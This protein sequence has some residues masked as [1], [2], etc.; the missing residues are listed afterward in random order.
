MPPRRKTARR[1]GPERGSVQHGRQH[2][3]PS[4]SLLCRPFPQELVDLIID[5]LY[6]DFPTLQI[7]SL[8]S[9]SFL[10]S[11][12]RHQFSHIEFSGIQ[13]PNPPTRQWRRLTLNTCEK[14][15]ALISE[16]PHIAPLVR[17][18]RVVEGSNFLKV[19]WLATEP[20]LPVVLRK[21]VNLTSISLE[22][23]DD[24]LLW[25]ALSH[26]LRESLSELFRS[27]KL[28]T[29]RFNEIDLPHPSE[30]FRMFEGSNLKHLLLS[31]NE[32]AEEGEGTESYAP[33]SSLCLESLELDLDHLPFSRALE[34]MLKAP[35]VDLSNLGVL[36]VSVSE[37]ADLPAVRELLQK[38]SGSLRQ[39]RVHKA[40]Q[41]LQSGFIRCASYT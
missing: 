14:F 38:V 6:D 34:F 29:A 10:S 20:L 40:G 17:D 3:T 32:F 33:N 7:C 18:L 31:A 25:T 36:Y 11:S 16:S 2:E 23:D 37:D 19:T 24:V 41:F 8:T 22:A 12:R 27:P 39:L 4:Q 35:S 21:L 26:R 1:K 5:E 9:R 15:H 13:P 28:E 30:F